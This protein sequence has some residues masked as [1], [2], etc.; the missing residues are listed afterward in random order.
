MVWVPLALLAITIM[1]TAVPT[2]FSPV[3]N[4]TY[5]ACG[6]YIDGNVDGVGWDSCV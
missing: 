5:Y 4:C 2:A 1:S 3:T 6:V